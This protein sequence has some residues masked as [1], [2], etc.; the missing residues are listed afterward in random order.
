MPNQ[1]VTSAP[2]ARQRR[3]ARLP[4]MIRFVIP[5]VVLV[6]CLSA[7]PR[8]SLADDDAAEV[9]SDTPQYCLDLAGRVASMEHRLAVPPPHE[10]ADLSQEGRRLCDQGQTRMGIARLRRALLMLRHPG[11]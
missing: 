9:T 2:C 7:G 10:V 6:V 8:V 3:R 1:L 4:G 5:A 11:E